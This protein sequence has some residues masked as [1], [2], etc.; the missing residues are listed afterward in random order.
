MNIINE[1]NVPPNLI[2]IEVTE[3]LFLSSYEA[4]IKTLRYLKSMGIKIALDDFGTGY[5]S[6]SYLKMLPIDVVK[7]DKSFVDDIV[8]SKVS[9]DLLRGIIDLM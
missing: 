6:L 5:S 8:C 1:F 7:I 4:N 3:T 2:E 9:R